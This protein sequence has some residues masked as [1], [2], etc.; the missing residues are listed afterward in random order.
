MYREEVG[1]LEVHPAQD[2]RCADMALV[3]AASKVNLMPI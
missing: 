2:K 3:P 1:T